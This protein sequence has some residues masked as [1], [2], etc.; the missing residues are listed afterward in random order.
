MTRTAPSS[1]DTMVLQS[2]PAPGQATACALSGLRAVR[3]V[4][5]PTYAPLRPR[6]SSPG[7]PAHLS[8]RGLVADK[9]D[10]LGP[11]AALKSP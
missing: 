8:R 10:V 9:A 5:T 7:A 6:R 4:P 11:A 3:G 1:S 2:R